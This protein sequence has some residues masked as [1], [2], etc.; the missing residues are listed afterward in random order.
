MLDLWIFPK[1][2]PRLQGLSLILKGGGVCRAASWGG[3][4]GEAARE[5]PSATLSLT[6]P[7]TVP[8]TPRGSPRFDESEQKRTNSLPR[9]RTG[10]LAASP[11]TPSSLQGQQGRAGRFLSRK[12]GGGGRGHTRMTRGGGTKAYKQ[13]KKLKLLPRVAEAWVA[14][15]SA[16]AARPPG[17]R[18]SAAPGSGLLTRQP[19]GGVVASARGV[20]RGS[21]AQRA[22]SI[23]QLSGRGG[24]GSAQ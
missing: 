9:I 2:P 4:G 5:L 17:P 1:P 22:C 24:R 14:R 21:Q 20:S 11:L 7:G 18:E 15:A 3:G 10:L 6:P 19:A 8:R 16:N 23:G 13:T 12:G